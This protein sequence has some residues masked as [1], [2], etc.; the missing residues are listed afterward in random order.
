MYAG[1]DLTF[2]DA[3][4]WADDS[5]SFSLRSCQIQTLIKHRIILNFWMVIEYVLCGLAIVS[6]SFVTELL[7]I[8]KQHW[9]VEMRTLAIYL[10]P[11]VP[12]RTAALRCIIVE[13][14]LQISYIIQAIKYLYQTIQY[15]HIIVHIVWTTL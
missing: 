3:W 5:I 11:W 1:L 9:M 13:G 12:Q 8:N 7:S 10:C 6:L 14:P 2:L 4:D 15:H